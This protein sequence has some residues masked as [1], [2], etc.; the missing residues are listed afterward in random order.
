MMSGGMNSGRNLPNNGGVSITGI[1][2]PPP[3]I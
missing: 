3:N 1:E 2:N